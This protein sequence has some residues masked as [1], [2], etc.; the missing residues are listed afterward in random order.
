LEKIAISLAAIAFFTTITSPLTLSLK[1]NASNIA[2]TI[3][4]L[5]LSCDR[6]ICVAG[7]LGCQIVIF[8]NVESINDLQ[9]F[10]LGKQYWNSGLGKAEVLEFQLSLVGWSGSSSFLCLTI[11]SNLSC[12]W[13]LS[14]P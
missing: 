7:E 8:V 11:A 10:F 14:Q 3:V 6:K 1:W 2:L 13:R 12:T 4:R 5:M 9:S